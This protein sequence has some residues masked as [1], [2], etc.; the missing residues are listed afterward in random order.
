MNDEQAVGEDALA[1][2]GG[3]LGQAQ[4][5]EK[6]AAGESAGQHGADHAGRLAVGVRLPGVHR[7]QAELGAVADQEQRE[8]SAQPGF[9]EDCRRREQVA[10]QQRRL[11][12][13]EQR[14]VTDEE[15]PE[16]RERDAHRRDDQVFPGRLDR[17]RGAVEIDQRRRRQGGRLDADPEQAEMLGV[18]DQAHAAESGQHAGA[19]SAIGALD[20]VAQ[21]ARRV[22]RAGQEKNAD[23]RQQQAARGVEAQPP[24]ARRAGR[25]G[26]YGERRS[27]RHGVRHGRPGQQARTPDLGRGQEHRD[28]HR[29]RQEHREGWNR[30]LL[31]Q[32]QSPRV[33]RRELAVDVVDDDAEHEDADEE[34]EQHADLDQEGHRLD[35]AAGRRRRCRFRGSGNRAPG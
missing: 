3:D 33:E 2:R 5:R 18:G 21:I 32:R 35:Q 29:E 20:P 28:G 30:L 27:G 22:D 7:H 34:V 9:R 8:A 12:S 31:E 19:E 24:G 26:R 1:R 4:E 15:R 11:T 14:R 13:A 17:L 16:Q 25:R 6:G 10:E 23:Q